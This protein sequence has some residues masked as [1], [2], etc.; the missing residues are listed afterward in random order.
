MFVFFLIGIY[1][2]QYSLNKVEQKLVMNHSIIPEHLDDVLI[3]KEEIQS[4]ESWIKDYIKDHTECKKAL[5]II[6]NIGYGKTVLA[7]LL[8]K[9]YNFQKIELN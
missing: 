6:G 4:M 9:K 2:K 3:Y 5:L 1:L 7:E 8:L